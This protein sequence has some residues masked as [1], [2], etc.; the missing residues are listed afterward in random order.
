VANGPHAPKEGSPS[1]GS[2]Q[3]RF[4]TVTRKQV[5]AILQ[6]HMDDLVRVVAGAG[7]VPRSV[8]RQVAR[9]LKDLGA[10]WRERRAALR[11]MRAEERRRRREAGHPSRGEAAREAAVEITLDVVFRALVEIAFQAI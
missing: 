5:E 11:A 9:D 1:P 6:R 8:Y 2:P 7:R 4:R 10:S 3:P